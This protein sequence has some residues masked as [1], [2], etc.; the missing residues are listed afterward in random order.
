[1]TAPR[2]R[3]AREY[4]HLE[5]SVDIPAWFAHWL[6]HH[7]NLAALRARVAGEDRGVDEVFTALASIAAGG[8]AAGSGTGTELAGPLDAA[9]PS[10]HENDLSTFDV[11]ELAGV[12]D[13]AIRKAIR[14]G[15]LA[16]TQ[17][18]TRYVIA[19]GAAERYAATATRGTTRS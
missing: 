14:A 16:A 10:V 5:P 19:R 9:P 18:G 3:F 13:T 12:S 11:A 8:S 7:A 4:L 2:Y 15:R 1:V 6:W 17:V